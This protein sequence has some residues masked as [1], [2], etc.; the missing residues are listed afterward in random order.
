MSRQ[1]EGK[2]ALVT[3]GNS[4]IGKATAVAFAKEG[5]KV[6][7]AARR[8]ALGRETVK[9]IRNV[10]GEAIFIKADMSEA[11]D[12]Q[13]MVN[14]TVETFGRLDYAFNNAGRYGGRPLLDATEEEWDEFMNIN[15]KGT[16]LCMKY[17]IP[18]MIKVGGGAIVN[19]SSVSGEG[20]WAGGSLYVASKH[21]INGLTKCAAIEF[22]KQGVRVNAVEPGIIETPAWGEISP[23]R[24]IE[25][26]AM[27]PIPRMASSDEVADPVIWLCSEQSSY[28]T[29][30]TL[31]V[32]GGMCARP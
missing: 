31:L 19:N 14:E 6:A 11:A 24:R 26:N 3:G 12:I 29:G 8:E 1:F 21:G 10:G 25:L 9:E 28:V 23:E 27:Q 5:A 22:A 20:G 17:E 15:L 7:I 2:V 4:G 18:E 32:D 13:A 30:V 16:W